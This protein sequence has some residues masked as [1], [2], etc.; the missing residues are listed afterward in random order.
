M[1]FMKKKIRYPFKSKEKE[2]YFILIIFLPSVIFFNPL[3]SKLEN[4]KILKKFNESSII[5]KV[6]EGRKVKEKNRE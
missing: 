2:I 4:K 1:N 5:G 6:F 3:S